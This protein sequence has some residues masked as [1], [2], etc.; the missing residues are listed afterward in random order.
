MEVTNLRV[1]RQKYH[2]SLSALA[3]KAGICNQHMSRIELGKIPPTK[4]HENLVT[5]ALY[6]VI[7]ERRREVANMEE[8]F[9]SHIGRLL[10]DAEG[11]DNES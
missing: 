5:G 3:Q 11:V 2:I 9:R 6:E 8:D 4:H 7:A 1:L 10:Q